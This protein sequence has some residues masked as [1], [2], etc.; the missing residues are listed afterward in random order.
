ME[1]NIIF[2]GVNFTIVRVL[3]AFI[4]HSANPF[5]TLKHVCILNDKARYLNSHFYWK[6]FSM[7]SDESLQKV[8]FYVYIFTSNRALGF[9]EV[10]SFSKQ[11]GDIMSVSNASVPN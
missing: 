11:N 4:V 5:Q 10:F 3:S 7:K 9:K 1:V 8:S 2:W 6:L